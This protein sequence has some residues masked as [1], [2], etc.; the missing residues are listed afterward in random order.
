[1]FKINVRYYYYIGVNF[2]NFMLGIS[3]VF[4]FNYCGNVVIFMNNVVYVCG[5]V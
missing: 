5:V 3:G 2:F 1:M 4:V